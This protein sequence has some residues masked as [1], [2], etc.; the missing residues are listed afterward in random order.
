MNPTPSHQFRA[1]ARWTS[2]RHGVAEGGP[3][4]PRIDFSAPLEFQGEAGVWTPEHFFL[5]AVA[6]CFVITFRAIS[7]LS[8]FEAS[9][10]EVTAEGILEK[11]EGGFSF[12]RVFVRPVLTVAREADQERGLRLLEK[13]ERSCLISRSLRGEV[14]LVPTVAVSGPASAA[15]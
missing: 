7:D 15:A 5:A 9:E 1:S 14:V 12:T 6:S 3:G 8:K 13:A 11:G 10:L 4:V 2:A